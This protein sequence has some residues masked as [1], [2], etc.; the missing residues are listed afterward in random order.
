MPI[1]RTPPSK[2]LSSFNSTSA[3][4]THPSTEELL[5]NSLDYAKSHTT[6][7]PEEEEL[8]MSCRKSVL[9]NNGKVW[10]KKDKDFD[11]TMGAQDGAEIAELTGIY[12]LKQV[13]DYL[14]SLGEKSEAGL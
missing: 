3:S 14:A 9:F 7:S 11:V 5:R 13:N 10:T 4:F 12:L 8:I 1:Q 2:K 6:I